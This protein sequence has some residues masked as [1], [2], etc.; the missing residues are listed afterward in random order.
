MVQNSQLFPKIRPPLRPSIWKAL[1]V[2]LGAVPGGFTFA[3]ENAME[4]H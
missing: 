2:T 1:E 4:N 3:M